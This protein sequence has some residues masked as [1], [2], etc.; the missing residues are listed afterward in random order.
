MKTNV[1]LT[2]APLFRAGVFLYVP[3]SPAAAE[4]NL[5]LKNNAIAQAEVA[6]STN[7][8]VLNGKSSMSLPASFAAQNYKSP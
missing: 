3:G 5:L 6:A 1:E 8:W 2:V 7:F 4:L